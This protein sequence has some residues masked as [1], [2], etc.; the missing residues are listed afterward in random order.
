MTQADVPSACKL[1]ADYLKK[2]EIFVDAVLKIRFRI[3]PVM[4]EEEFAHW[5]LPREG[6]MSTYVLQVA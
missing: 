1:L 4:S 5:L 3:A 6:V 2:Y